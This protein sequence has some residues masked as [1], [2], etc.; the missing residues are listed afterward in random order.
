MFLFDILVSNCTLLFRDMEVFNLPDTTTACLVESDEVL[1][2]AFTGLQSEQDALYVSPGDS[3][4]MTFFDITH[5]WTL[6][7]EEYQFQMDLH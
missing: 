4:G 2:V 3:G 7:S 6:P 5:H 1:F